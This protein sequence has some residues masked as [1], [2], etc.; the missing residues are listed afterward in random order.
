MKIVAAILYAVSTSVLLAIAFGFAASG[1]NPRLAACALAA[2]A[3]IGAYSLL[4]RST[5]S[6]LFLAYRCSSNS[7]NSSRAIFWSNGGGL[8]PSK[9]L[10][11]LHNDCVGI[12]SPGMH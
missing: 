11:R 9:G 8:G 7:S 6:P 10:H 12:R 4:Q 1:L 3:V 5:I 2:G